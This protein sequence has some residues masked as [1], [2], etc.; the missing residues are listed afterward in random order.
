MLLS[1]TRL[2]LLGLMLSVVG[3]QAVPTAGLPET[4]P[5]ATPSPDS[6]SAAF[7][8]LPT[9]T[10]RAAL[11]PTPKPARGAA[12]LQER[13]LADLSPAAASY[14]DARPGSI[15]V[16]VVVPRHGAVYT[17]NGEAL[18]PLASVAKV[19]IMA[20]LLDRASRAGR[21]LAP[22]ERDLLEP[23]ITVS[24][25]EAATAL[26]ADLGGS[27]GVDAFVRA[28]DLAEIE[29]SSGPDWGAS[30][31]SARA[32]ALLLARLVDGELLPE[33]FRGLALDLLT[34]VDPAQRW[35][36]GAVASTSLVP[37]P[38]VGIKDGWYPDEDGWWVNS[39]GFVQAAEPVGTYTLA[40]LTREQPSFEDGVDT[41]EGLARLVDAALQG[42]VA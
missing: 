25:N 7:A 36:V 31:A 38:L 23:M 6:P 12:A 14:L 22:E 41:I 37:P 24:D 27:A 29:P 26:W 10:S 34:R 39:A 19:V 15:A 1:S 40:V 21:D 30:R 9:P 13:P 11:L 2:V 18:F 4:R 20:A 42:P 35:G 5:L 28:T 3:C 16:A 17:A 33:P 32:V 8:A